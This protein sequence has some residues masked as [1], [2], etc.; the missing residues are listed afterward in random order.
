MLN[1]EKCKVGLVGCGRISHSHFEAIRQLNADLELVAVCD[2]N[3]N[4]FKKLDELSMRPRQYGDYERM[5]RENK[6]DLMVICTPSG[7]HSEHGILASRNKIHVLTEKPMATNLKDADRLIFEC[8]QNDVH[9][10][11]VKQNR[12]NRTIQY[13]KKAIEIGRFGKIYQVI[14]NVLW[15][16]PQNYYDMDAWRGKRALDGGAFLN[17]SSHYVDL[18]YYLFGEVKSV[19]ALT[20]TLARKIE[21][22]DSGIAV[23]EFENGVIG[24]MNTSMLTYPKNYEGSITII[25]EKGTVKIGGIAVNKIEKWEFSEYHD[26]DKEVLDSSYDTASVYGTGHF[27]FYQKIMEHLRE[28]NSIFVDGFDG[29][30]SLEII[31]GIYRS[32]EESK[33]VYF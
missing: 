22:E 31:M 24:T 23:F 27:H 2:N 7:L 32:A 4:Q 1:A 21:V 17:Q 19:F 5:I 15:T 29:R 11:V 12:L 20:R 6:I 3:P 13:L 9:L 26:M 33:I 30:K 25:G 14:C 10:Y 28:E 16:R 18:M 8:S